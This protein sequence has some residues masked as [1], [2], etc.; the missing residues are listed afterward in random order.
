MRR[1]INQD[2]YAIVLADTQNSWEKY[3][4]L[5]IVA[6]G[7]GA[8]AA[9]ELASKLSVEL[10][11]HHY[12]KL[13]DQPP[14]ESLHQS[15][16]NANAEIFRRGQANIE[17]RSMGTTCSTLTLAPEGA[18]VAH[19]GDS[20]VYQ[21]RGDQLFQ[22]TFD[23][24]LV[25][26]MQAAGELTDE[27][28][29]S[30]VIPKNVITRSLGPNANVQIDLE[31]PFPVKRGD[32]F[33]LCSDGLS[34]QVSDEELAS[35]LSALPPQPACQ[36]LID[37]S[38]LRGG[39]DNITAIVVEVAEDSICSAQPGAIAAR[40]N[41]APRTFSPALGI[42]AAVCISAAGLLCLLG[43]IP[44]GVV[45]AVLGIIAL[46]TGLVQVLWNGNSPA[47]AHG[48]YGQGPHRQFKAGN[49][50][51]FEQLA[52]TMKSLREASE[53]RGWKIQWD[54]LEGQFEKAKQHAAAGNFKQAVATQGKVIIEL[55]K[56]IR[57]QRDT[58]ASDS[59]ID[60]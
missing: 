20:R 11:P 24:S 44:L 18:V 1:A 2:S 50:P 29:R 26:E 16:L 6:D 15:I 48:R 13:R 27:T 52:G 56:Q 34:G 10:I 40:W 46:G 31:G 4:H 47:D 42:V 43:N 55:M 21:M 37:L 5:F 12:F 17:F 30:G 59:A 41:G 7:M 22:L 3:G 60:L 53:E 9:G 51:L 39:P 54:L 28:A 45:A 38:N 32:V 57:G 8:H 23:H 35:I 36:L 33:L 14:A 58:P 19:V 49:Q 25:W